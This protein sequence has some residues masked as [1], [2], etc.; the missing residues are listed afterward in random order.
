MLLDDPLS[1]VD[2]HVAKRLYNDVI[3]GLLEDRAVVLVTHHPHF[4]R[5]ADKILY[6]GMLLRCWL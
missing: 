3:R 2:P 4:M 6:L 5:D 1:A